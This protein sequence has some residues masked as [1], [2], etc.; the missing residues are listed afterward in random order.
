M[1]APYSLTRRGHGFVGV[2]EDYFFGEPM[3]IRALLKKIG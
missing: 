2:A 1:T 3:T